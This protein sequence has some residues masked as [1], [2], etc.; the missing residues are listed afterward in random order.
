MALNR[1]AEVSAVLGEEFYE[2]LDQLEARQDFESGKYKCKNCRSRIDKDNV[3]L[4]FPMDNQRIGFLCR[5][6][7]CVVEY[8]VST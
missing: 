3:L 2:L 4:M 7:E 1:Q 6:P 5:N 8:A